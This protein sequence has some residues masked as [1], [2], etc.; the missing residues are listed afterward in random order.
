MYFLLAEQCLMFIWRNLN[1]YEYCFVLEYVFLITWSHEGQSPKNQRPTTVFTSFANKFCV[2]VTRS[3]FHDRFI[4]VSWVV[5]I[6][7]DRYSKTVTTNP[8]TILKT[9][10]IF[11]NEPRYIGPQGRASHQIGVHYTGFDL[12]HQVYRTRWSIV[13]IGFVP[14]K[15]SIYLR[16]VYAYFHVEMRTIYHH[17]SSVLASWVTINWLQIIL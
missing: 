4:Q 9:I 11:C 2:H 17:A 12:S 1:A 10:V 6:N 15:L 16:S 13:Y 14:R 8:I 7:Y 3:H 5:L